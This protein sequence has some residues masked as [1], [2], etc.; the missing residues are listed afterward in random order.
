MKPFCRSWSL[1]P[2]NASTG[3]EFGMTSPDKDWMTYAARWHVLSDLLDGYFS[4]GPFV[5]ALKVYH[6]T[7][8][9]FYALV[10]R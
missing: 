5:M 8:W 7:D 4:I 6:L 10:V 1:K 9:R 3:F 2:N